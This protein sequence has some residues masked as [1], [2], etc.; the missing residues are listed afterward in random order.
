MFSINFDKRW[1]WSG[2]I[3]EGHAGLQSA[4]DFQLGYDRSCL[5]A[6]IEEIR[7]KKKGSENKNTIGS[8]FVRRKA[9]RSFLSWAKFLSESVEV[10]QK[11][12]VRRVAN[13]IQ[14]GAAFSVN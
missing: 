12:S 4:S 3:N 7:W 6:W 11:R 10:G 8:G 13:I 1:T 9:L 14:V 5:F 2:E